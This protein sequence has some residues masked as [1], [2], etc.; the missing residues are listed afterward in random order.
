MIWTCILAG[1]IAFA[2]PQGSG[3]DKQSS[4]SYA[5]KKAAQGSYVFGWM[6]H[7]QSNLQLRGGTTVGVPV[8]LETAVSEEWTKLQEE[9]L[10]PI[11]RDRRAILAMAGDYRVSF[12]FL[13]VEVYGAVQ[14]PST[15]YRSWATEQVEVLESTEDIISL[16]HT[17]VM[18]MVMEDGSQSPPM[19]VKHWR[20]DWEYEPETALEFIGEMHWETR[21][22]SDEERKGKWQQT[23][24]QVD[25]SP[26]Y[27]MRGAW[28]HNAAY[29]AWHGEDS[30]RPLPR[31]EHSI[32]SD[33]HTL[34][35][36]NR[37]TIHPKGWVHTQDNMKTVLSTIG[38]ID[39][40][41]PVLAR[42]FGVNRYDRIRDFDF[43]EADEYW[44]ATGDFWAK[45]RDAW[46][47]HLTTSTTVK[48]DT[49]CEDKRVYGHLFELANK[50]ATKGMSDKKQLKGIE[51]VVT[52]AI[53]AVE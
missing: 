10:D 16:Q 53:S 21:Q 42:E 32:R 52:C 19:L 4:S 34:T 28:E 46:N 50:V 12:D 36:T 51:K 11:E 3:K 13:E 29:S 25:D 41:N 35:G 27:T 26:R 6:D 2:L 23:V 37:L 44:A 14:A 43:S 7:Q 31:R 30:W 20:Q 49:H 17:I 5:P 1:S 18:F 22:L 48:V 39:A 47:N 45:T 33:Y 8:T 40:N 15:P 38:T 9:N 24:Y